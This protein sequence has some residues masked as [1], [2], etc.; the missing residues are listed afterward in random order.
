M[1][2]ISLLE[3]S[4]FLPIVSWQLI[5]RLSGFPY[6][7]FGTVFRNNAVVSRTRLSSINTAA[8]KRKS[9]QKRAHHGV[10]IPL[11]IPSHHILSLLSQAEEHRSKI[12]MCTSPWTWSRPNF[13]SSTNLSRYFDNGTSCYVSLQAQKA[14]HNRR[15]RVGGGGDCGPCDRTE[16][17]SARL[18]IPNGSAERRDLPAPAYRSSGQRRSVQSRCRR[19]RLRSV[20]GS[21]ERDPPK[22]RLCSG[23]RRGDDVL[24]RAAQYAFG[25]DRRR[26][27]HVG[28]PARDTNGHSDRFPRGR[29]QG[30]DAGHVRGR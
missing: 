22:E 6:L 30:S 28:L 7:V 18:F 9:G 10:S 19:L 11:N 1:I 27:V 21:R 3:K 4:C 29:A 5:M 8:S 12:W 17:R 23:H 2:K 25:W 13:S 26:R 16:H 14:L 20:L 15:G 24:R